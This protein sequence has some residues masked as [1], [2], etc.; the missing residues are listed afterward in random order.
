MLYDVRMLLPELPRMIMNHFVYGLALYTLGLIIVVIT[1]ARIL[2]KR[3]PRA[4]MMLAAFGLLH[5]SEEWGEA[6]AHMLESIYGYPHASLGEV[7]LLVMVAVAYYLLLLFGIEMLRISF[8]WEK[9]YYLPAIFLI[10]YVLGGVLLTMRFNENPEILLQSLRNWTSY[11]LGAFGGIVSGLGLILWSRKCPSAFRQVLR[12]WTIAGV[13]LIIYGVVGHLTAEPGVIF[14][15][16]IYNTVVFHQLFGFSVEPL[17]AVCILFVLIGLLFALQGLE[18]ERQQ[19]FALAQETARREASHR[20]ALQKTLLHRTVAAQEEER[21]RVA[22]ELHDETGQTLTALNYHVSALESVV[23]RQAVITPDMI[24]EVRSLTNRALADMHQIV[25]DLRPAQLD[26]LGLV[27][28]IHWLGSD[29]H[30]RL[31]LNASI[32]VLGKRRRLPGEIETA[33]FR[34]TQESLTNVAR[35]SGAVEACVRLTFRDD[36]V[37]LIIIDRG[38]GFD[39]LQTVVTQNDKAETWGMIGMRE[40]A[41]SLGGTLKVRSRPGKGTVIFVNIPGC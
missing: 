28:A 1:D 38:H 32:H 17:R 16:N 3:L 19:A 14:P 5:G 33:L 39:P 34:I 22:R 4:L 21:A 7:I 20:E 8:N 2:D 18:Q 37:Y 25:T 15:S 35:H 6:F 41:E 31:G 13:P 9:R 29:V 36:A 27:A 24:E 40:R 30:K 23:Q 12:G 26:D 10:I 11:S